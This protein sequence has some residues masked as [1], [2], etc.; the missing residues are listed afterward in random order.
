MTSTEPYFFLVVFAVKPGT[1]AKQGFEIDY[2]SVVFHNQSNGYTLIELLITLAVISVLAL[3]VFP[4]LSALLAKERTV[5][6]TN[7]LASALAFARAES[8][9]KNQTIITCQSNNGS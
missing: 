9:T 3:N 7:N 1:K 4:N 2:S 6:M 5:V 8:V